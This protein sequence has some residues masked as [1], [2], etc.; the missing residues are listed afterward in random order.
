MVQRPLLIALLAALAVAMPAA[1]QEGPASTD[2]LSEPPTGCLP[3][4]PSCGPVDQPAAL[5][6]AEQPAPESPTCRIFDLTSD[7]PAHVVD[8]D[9]CWRSWLKRAIGVSQDAKTLTPDGTARKTSTSLRL[10]L[11]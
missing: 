7:Q 11:T 2:T 9:G 10:F 5:V 8:P 6:L 4:D 3:L 1:A